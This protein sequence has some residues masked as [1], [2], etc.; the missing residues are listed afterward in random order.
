MSLVIIESP[1]AG[2]VE[3]NLKYLRACMRDALLRGESPY[4]SH[5][6]LTQPGVLD[7]TVPQERELGIKAGFEWH[8]AADKMVV[9]TDNGISSGMQRGIENA[10]RIGLDVEMRRL[11]GW[12]EIP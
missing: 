2:D 12:V 10:H 4:A 7:D 8:K 3:A 5:G 6:L 11:S 1:F 9:Y